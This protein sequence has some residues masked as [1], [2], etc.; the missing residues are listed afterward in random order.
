MPYKKL[1]LMNSNFESEQSP[2][3][4]KICY[5]PVFIGGDEYSSIFNSWTLLRKN[6]RLLKSLSLTIRL[7]SPST[8]A[9]KGEI[10]PIT[11]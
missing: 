8:I 2:K 7:I 4:T 9:D 1:F 5:V 11:L 3:N 10:L 6:L